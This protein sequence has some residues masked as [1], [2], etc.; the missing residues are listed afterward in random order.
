MSWYSTGHEDAERLAAST[1]TRRTRNFFTKPGESARIRFLRP[2]TESFNYKRAFVPW[3]KGQKLLTSPD[4]VPDPFVERGLSLQAAFAWP[5]IDRR[6][7]EIEDR[8]TGEK[9]EI[10]PRILYF[11]DGQRTRKQLVAFEREM[12]A[13]INEDREEEGKE[14]FT[15]AEFNLTSYDIKASKEKRAPWN[16]VAVTPKPLSDVDKEMMEKGAIDLREE[17]KPLPE[18]DLKSLLS[19]GDT[20]LSSAAADTEDESETYSYS[21]DD[22]DTISFS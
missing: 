7:F 9:K 12:L 13:T 11:A 5:I 19:Q 10:G 17:L 15:L 4:T 8:D 6:T 3:A 1:V 16:F 21:D 18:A 14:P 2:A 20:S 22:D